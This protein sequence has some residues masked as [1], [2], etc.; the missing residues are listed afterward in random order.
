MRHGHAA[1][2]ADG[3]EQCRG[4]LLLHGAVQAVAASARFSRLLQRLGGVATRLTIVRHEH[5]R[6]LRREGPRRRRAD[7]VIGPGDQ[8]DL[9]L[10]SSIN[11]RWRSRPSQADVV[12][13]PRC[14]NH[15]K[16]VGPR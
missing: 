5:I 13:T 11:H 16:S 6:A 10:Q 14:L 1:V 7:A 3:L 12:A 2:C 8:Y 15:S 9:V 4:R